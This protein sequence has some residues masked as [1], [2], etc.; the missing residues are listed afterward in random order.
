MQLRSTRDELAKIEATDSV[1]FGI[2]VDYVGSLKKFQEAEHFG[3]SLLADTDHSVSRLY[4]GI[5]EE[6]SASNRMTFVIDKAGYVRAIEDN[7]DT[8]NHGSNVV[9]LLQQSLPSAIEVGETAPDF[10]AIDQDGKTYQLRQ[11]RGKQ[12]VVLAFY[13]TDFTPG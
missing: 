10:I 7:V 3:F 1:V 2:S 4:S 12:K 8:A 11:F 9:K 13:P 5:R 6:S